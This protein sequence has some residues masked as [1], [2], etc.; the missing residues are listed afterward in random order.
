MVHERGQELPPRQRRRGARAEPRL[1][2][3]ARR[4]ELDQRGCAAAEAAESA[5]EAQQEEAKVEE[6]STEGIKK[7]EELQNDY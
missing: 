7:F 6:M 3:R 4:D 1:G 5:V 2:H